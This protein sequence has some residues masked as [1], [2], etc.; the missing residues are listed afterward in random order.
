M[1]NIRYALLH[2]NYNCNLSCPHCRVK[3]TDKINQEPTTAS[4]EYAINKISGHGIP[5]ITLTGGEPTIR[6]DLLHL[7]AYATNNNIKVRLQTNGTNIN[8]EFINK[9][10]QAGGT[11]IS[12]SI[13]GV[14]DKHDLVRGKIGLYDHIMSCIGA[15]SKYDLHVQ[16]DYMLTNNCIDDLKELTTI[17]D[18]SSVHL[19]SVRAMV[20]IIGNN[21]PDAYVFTNNNYKTTLTEV[22]RLSLKLHNLKVTSPDP[23]YKLLDLNKD[24]MKRYDPINGC[25]IAGCSVGLGTISVQPNGDVLLCSF[26][27]DPIGNIYETDIDTMLNAVSC[28][29]S[30]KRFINRESEGN[31]SD[32]QFKYACG[33]CR[34]RSVYYN[35]N[36]HGEDPQCWLWK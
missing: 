32:C 25:A 12:F 1:D 17:L 15:C 26:I 9:F 33:G 8:N 23:L 21:L 14:G 10:A 5:L 18:Q 29:Q 28:K 11:A 31:C 4:L 13:D 3:Y 2:V 27:Y 16:V 7:V 34:A 35:N 20:P 36:V 6:N 22:K 19:L 24:E 30:I